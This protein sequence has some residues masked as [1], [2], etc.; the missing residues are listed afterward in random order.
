MAK[1]SFKASLSR[2]IGSKTQ[3]IVNLL[4]TSNRRQV[5]RRQGDFERAGDEH[6]RLAGALH[7][8]ASIS[9][10]PGQGHRPF[11]ACFA[12]WGGHD[13]VEDAALAAAMASEQNLSGASP[14][15]RSVLSATAER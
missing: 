11:P 5:N 1:N 9:V 12:D 15:I 13:G 4:R 6:H 2:S 3:P 7:F 10:C 14:A 8:W